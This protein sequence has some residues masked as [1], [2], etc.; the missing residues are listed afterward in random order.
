M[1]EVRADSSLGCKVVQSP[2]SPIASTTMKADTEVIANIALPKLMSYH[3][4]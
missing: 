2:M 1:G 4:A 3:V